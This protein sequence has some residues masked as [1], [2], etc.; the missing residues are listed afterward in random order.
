[1][2]NAKH[3]LIAVDASEASYRAVTSVGRIIGGRED[4]RVCLLHA[5]PVL[6]QIFI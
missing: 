6:S 1:M 4:F 2:N 3:M 5:S